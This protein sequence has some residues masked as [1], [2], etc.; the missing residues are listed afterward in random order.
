MPNLIHVLQQSCTSTAGNEGDWK[1]KTDEERKSELQRILK[2]NR[3]QTGSTER[4]MEWGTCMIFSCEKDCCVD[5]NN[6]NTKE[7]WAEELVMIQWEE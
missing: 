5:E 4:G 7:C 2:V 3:K 1:N 6:Q